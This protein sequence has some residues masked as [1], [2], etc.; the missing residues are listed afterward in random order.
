VTLHRVVVG[1][2]KLALPQG[3]FPPIIIILF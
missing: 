2:H 3:T 1:S